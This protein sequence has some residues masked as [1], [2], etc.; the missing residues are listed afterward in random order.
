[1]KSA[2]VRLAAVAAS[3]ATPLLLASCGDSRT[4]AGAASEPRIVTSFY[5]LQYVAER[6]ASEHAQVVSLTGPGQEPHDLELSLKQTAAVSDASLVVYEKGFQGAVDEAVE[7]TNPAHVVDAA[8]VADLRD[9]DPHFWLDPRRLRMVA[10]AVYAELL[11]VDP[12][13]R[14]DYRL[15]HSALVGDLTT[16]DERAAVTLETC[17]RRTIVVS[18]DA[19]GYLGSRYALD[20][21]AING[22][23]PHAEP[24]PAHIQQLSQLI[25]EQGITTV[26]NEELASAQMATT[27][28]E[29]LGLETA[30]LDP[31]EGLSD[32]TADEDYLSLMEKNLAALVKAN[33]CT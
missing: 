10:D 21:H 9:A 3:L 24:S 4:S 19:F 23:S 5:A 7:T 8:E 17:E 2:P 27:L 26:F 28:A 12:D 16:F 33:D 20:V 30:V 18:H 15:N 32:D 11:E 1:M 13:H 31:V 6:L 25:E 14:E 22:L 29:D